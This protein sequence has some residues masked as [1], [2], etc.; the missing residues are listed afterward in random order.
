MAGGAYSRAGTSEKFITGI[1]QDYNGH[2]SHSRFACARE[3]AAHIL[4]ASNES[5]DATWATVFKPRR[6]TPCLLLCSPT[7]I[8]F[9]RITHTNQISIRSVNPLSIIPALQAPHVDLQIPT[10]R[11]APKTI[12]YLKIAQA[13]AVGYVRRHGIR[14]TEQSFGLL[15]LLDQTSFECV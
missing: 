13:F 8:T 9:G 15:R 7:R 12:V 3:P 5:Q 11:D 6:G 14:S 2:Q 10:G 4:T 1:T